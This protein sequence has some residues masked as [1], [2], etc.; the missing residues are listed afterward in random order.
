MEDCIWLETS[1][2]WRDEKDLNFLELFQSLIYTKMIFFPKMFSLEV[3]KKPKQP[4][5]FVD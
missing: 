2:V 5:V 4:K 1:D 3:L